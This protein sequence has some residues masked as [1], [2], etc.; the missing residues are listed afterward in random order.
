[1]MSP[2]TTAGPRVGLD[3]LSNAT[4]WLQIRVP[5]PDA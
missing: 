5:E 1:V 4:A 2:K 3:I